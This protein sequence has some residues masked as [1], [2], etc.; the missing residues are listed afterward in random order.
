MA[1]V[2]GPDMEML[3]RFPEPPGSVQIALDQLAVLRRGDPKEI[4]AAGQDLSDLPR[5]WDP[6]TCPARLRAATWAW[7]DDVANWINHEF[8]WRPNLMIPACWPRH[9]HIARELPVL[10]CQRWSAEQ[11]TGYD[12]IDDWHRY[13]LPLF[14]ERMFSRLG[15]GNCRSGGKHDDWPAESRHTKYAATAETDARLGVF[16]ADTQALTARAPR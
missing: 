2:N 11:A 15:E 10:A 13:A 9:P 6:S 1:V 4:D 16:R 3:A 12:L 5:P 8:A 14:L 7:C